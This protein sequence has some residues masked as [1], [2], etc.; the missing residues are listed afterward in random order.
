MYRW[1]RAFSRCCQRQRRHPARRLNRTGSGRISKKRS[2][3][4]LVLSIIRYRHCDLAQPTRRLADQGRRVQIHKVSTYRGAARPAPGEG[5]ARRSK[6]WNSNQLA[7]L[8]PHQ[9]SGWRDVV[10]FPRHPNG[11]RTIVCCRK[12]NGWNGRS[13]EAAKNR[14]HDREETL[15]E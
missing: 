6:P 10:F 12:R 15:F 11:V 4:L 14:K 7:Q 2:S 3:L 5:M 1:F 13:A 8:Q 9:S